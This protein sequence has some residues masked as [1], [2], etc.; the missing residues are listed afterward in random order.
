MNTPPLKI[1]LADDHKVVRSGLVAILNSHPE[2]LVTVEAS[3]GRELLN[4]LETNKVDVVLLDLEMPILGG[5]ETLQEIRKINSEVKVLILTM[6]QHNAFILQMIRLG[7]NGY[8]VKTTAPNELVAAIKSAHTTG[9]FFS[10]RVSKAMLNGI[11]DPSLIRSADLPAH[12]LTERESEVLRL[13]CQELTTLEIGEALFLSPK[14]IE[15]YRKVLMEKSG[16]RNMA[17]LVLYA[18]RHGLVEE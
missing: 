13:I 4:K 17:G 5:K 12:G 10:E 16:A 14:T 8:L 3:N 18:V 1:A 9:F 2:F 7:A 11:A 15:G 6:H